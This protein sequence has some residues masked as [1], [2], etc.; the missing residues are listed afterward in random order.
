MVEYMGNG[1]KIK[2]RQG[3]KLS[4]MFNERLGVTVDVPR[5]KSK[6]R[7][8]GKVLVELYPSIV[9]QLKAA[10]DRAV[11]EVNRRMP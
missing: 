5:R 7:L 10:C 3:A 4:E 2:T 8:G 9:E 11:D 6:S 1:T